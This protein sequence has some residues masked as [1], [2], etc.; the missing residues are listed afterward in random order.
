MNVL[1]IDLGT[2]N[3]AAA[4][5]LESG[6]LISILA[7]A[8][9]D[10]AAGPSERVKPFPSVVVFSETG[11][12]A[13][14]GME[15]KAMALTRPQLT[16]FGIKR[17][18]G[19]TYREAL[20]HGEL[21]RMVLQVQ[22]DGETG[23]CV[24]EVGDRQV[25][26]E[27]VCAAI[28]RHIRDAAERTVGV[29]FTSAVISVPAYFDSIAVGA[30]CEAAKL[31][32]FQT[33]HAVPEP[34]A[35]A[36]AMN[37]TIT[38]R[39]IRTLTF[40][41]G[42]GTLDVTAAEVWRTSQGPTGLHCECKKNTGDIRLGGLDFD[43]R[44]VDYLSEVLE[45]GTL[46][47]EDRYRLRRAAEAA[48]V[49]LSSESSAEVSIRIEDRDL[50]YSL[51]RGE[52]E[53][54]LRREPDLLAACA[55]Q[56][57]AAIRGAGWKPEEV[58]QVL[59]VGGPSAM[60]CVRRVLRETFFRNPRV[61]QQIEG[62]GA[63]DPML[64]VASG[65]AKFKAAQTVNRHPYGYGYV[66]S[67]LEELPSKGAFTHRREAVILV[68]RDSA[69]PNQPVSVAARMAFAR[70]DN[71]VSIELIQQVAD[72]ERQAVSVGASEYRF[73]GTCDLAV[74]PAPLPACILIT[75]SLNENGELETTLVNLTGSETTRYIG[76]GGMQRHPIEL[77][78]SRVHQQFEPTGQWVFVPDGLD[79][80]RQWAMGLA[81]LLRAR[82][83]V[84]QR[85][86]P[87]FAHGLQ[88]LEDV[89]CEQDTAPAEHAV[90]RLY[91]AGKSLMARAFELRFVSE[92]ERAS[93][94]S[95]LEKARGRC[96]RFEDVRSAVA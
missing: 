24:L 77:P 12:I 63:V 13:A 72:S 94:A 65:A 67:V 83:L 51:T 55:E 4:V 25:R 39:P 18:L 59:L 46:V 43:D 60:P 82:H 3:S 57:R 79:A 14:V 8:A 2:N 91:N 7:T 48:K 26:P 87:Y 45:L 47:D 88:D 36:L 56:V 80:V 38:P 44:L 70:R 74:D 23:R 69:F 73:L 9:C 35:A 1:G 49:R 22:P 53:D 50:T 68:P 41:I 27:E 58:D 15:A 66:A 31:A 95:E 54:V 20:E 28:L 32:G 92:P 90:N 84:G 34:V 93:L 11:E 96:Y 85:A 62:V 76:V 6:E 81:R 10:G 75:M 86:D 89:L 21:D 17:L 16:A 61:L 5:M 33:V 40:D 71:V 42:A 52:L 30:T 78:T 37:L 64:A 19:K 29:K